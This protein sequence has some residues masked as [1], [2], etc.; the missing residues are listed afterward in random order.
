MI[1]TINNSERV[2]QIV[3]GPAKQT[4]CNLTDINIVV[5]HYN[6]KEGFYTIYEFWNNKPRKITSKA[7]KEM[8][9]ANG[10]EQQFKY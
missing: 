4:F 9:E 6:L 8:F 7:L 10:I 1:T 2:F 5:K 3:S